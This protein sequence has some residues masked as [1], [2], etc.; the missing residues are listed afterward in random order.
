[1]TNPS[2]PQLLFVYGTLR[3]QLL[4]LVSSPGVQQLVDRLARLGR[5]TIEGKIYDLGTFPGLVLLAEP[6]AD[7]EGCS[8]PP[9]LVIGD[10]L[11]VDGEA[12]ATL[13]NYEECTGASPLYRRDQVHAVC[14][15][16]GR[17]VR[18]WTYVF[19][20]DLGAAPRIEGG[21][22]ARYLSHVR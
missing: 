22:Y 2:S 13:D 18:A 16:D 6:P 4:H 10:L 9:P 12:L 5:A 15:D 19:C 20:G 21:D 3:P 17:T 14:Q 8:G 1:M 11:S 7:T